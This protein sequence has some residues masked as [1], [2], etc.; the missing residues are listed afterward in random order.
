LIKFLIS[1]HVTYSQE[2]E[3]LPKF[4]KLTL[5]EWQQFQAIEIEFNSR[6]TVLTGANG[7]GK[8]T[9]LNLL[10]RHNNWDVPYLSTPKASDKSGVIKFISRL[11]RGIDISDQPAIG[12]LLY[13][14]DQSA[15]IVVPNSNVPNYQPIIK[16]QQSVPCFFIPSH[17]SV[18]RYQQ[19]TSIP[20]ARINKQEAF[21]KVWGVSRNR[22]FG[23]NELPVS[24]HM[25]EV[26]IAWS[27]FGRGNEDMPAQNELL[28]YYEGFQDILR[29]VLPI[30]L[31][32]ERFSIRN[33]EVV[34][35][36]KS[37]DFMFDGVSGGL[38]TLID[39]AW[40]L[41]MFSTEESMDFTVLIDEAE[42][43]LHPTMQR[44]ILS[45]FL[46]AFPRVTFIVSTH[47]PL[48]VNSVREA[49]V[50]VLRYNEDNRIISQYLDFESKARTASQ[51]L[52]EVLGVSFTMPI[53]VEGE[54]DSIVKQFSDQQLDESTF[55]TIR[56]KLSAIGLQ[57]Y[58]PQTLAIILER[59]TQ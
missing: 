57:D 26:L 16:N 23:G 44:R 43:H 13:D 45:D 4:K 29:K 59:L 31:G 38:G 11:F 30:S 5:N 19:V 52:D 9:L 34:L 24:Y 22:Y 48:I 7:S 32:F 27:I 17:R 47:S 58:Y 54:L 1:V 41:F 14:N 18:Y 6:L 15:Q 35:Q 10:A 36:C 51:I 12:T 39:L 3:T 42:N 25:K 40:D 37:G 56:S 33:L 55:Q 8:T 53:W 2:R 20:V 50:Y 46:N 21:Q 28:S 49:S